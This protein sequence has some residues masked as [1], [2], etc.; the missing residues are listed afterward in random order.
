MSIVPSTVSSSLLPAASFSFPPQPS[1]ERPDEAGL[2]TSSRLSTAYSR[3]T[4]LDL[5]NHLHLAVWNSWHT[6]S[7]LSGGG[8]PENTAPGSFAYGGK[9]A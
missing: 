4:S 6:S 9:S 1:R 3:A 2:N 5:L 8:S 7:T